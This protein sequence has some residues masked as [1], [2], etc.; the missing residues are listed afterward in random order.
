[1]K[2]KTKLKPKK[3]NKNNRDGHFMH[4]GASPHITRDVRDWLDDM[5]QRYGLLGRQT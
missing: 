1:M 3:I 4:D 2:N 5:V